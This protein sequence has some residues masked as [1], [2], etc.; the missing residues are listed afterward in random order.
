MEYLTE[1][2]PQPLSLVPAERRELLRLVRR[3]PSDG[4]AKIIEALS[5]T[6]DD[7]VYELPPGPFVGRFALQSGRILDI[8]SRLIPADEVH[9]VLQVAGYLPS[10]LDDAPTPAQRGWGIV[11]VLAL[12]LATETERLI[13]RGLA[14]GYERRRFHSPPLPGT[15]DIREHLSR[16]AARPDKLVTVARRLTSN[17]D[18][19]QALTAATAILLR[20]PLQ[21][22]VRLRLRRI[23]AALISISAATMSAR[24][25]EQLIGEQRQAR[26]DGALRLC[27]AILRGS[28]IASSGGGIT[29]ASVL[30]SMPQVWEDFVL[31]WARQRHVGYH[32]QGQYSFP[33]FNR[34][35]SPTIAADVLV[36]G[37]PKVLYD[38]KYKPSGTTPQHNPELS[39]KAPGARDRGPGCALRSDRREEPVIPME[40]QH[41]CPDA[42]VS[43]RLRTLIVSWHK[44]GGA[45][46]DEC[47]YRE[48]HE[49]V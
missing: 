18:R 48:R 39:S 35:A 25:V 3:G 34:R 11:D 28:T 22:E 32:V 7:G 30:F 21:A 40:T 42:T 9:A 10:R 15:I 43:V 37:S 24:A 1:W 6:D 17:I 27:A 23:A 46:F 41:H 31:A 20:L 26:Y 44:T 2:K 12:A 5:P 14:K 49:V 45:V 16:Y 29:G 36:D 19:N 13:G 47:D 8:R 33:L 38:A 4:H